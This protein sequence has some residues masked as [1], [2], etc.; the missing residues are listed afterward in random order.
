MTR[1]AADCGARLRHTVALRRVFCHL[2]VN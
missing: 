1:W 2:A